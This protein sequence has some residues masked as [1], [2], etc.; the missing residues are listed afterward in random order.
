MRVSH[1]LKTWSSTQKSIT[2]SSA[3]AEL[4]AA[5]KASTELIWTIQMELDWGQIV[6][7]EVYVD[8][9][10]ALAVV[11]GKGNGKLRH[12]KVGCLWIQEKQASGE[13]HYKRVPWTMN[14]SDAMT[15]HL[16]G[17]RLEELMK[18]MS[19]LSRTGRASVGLAVHA[20]AVA[21]G[22]ILPKPVGARQKRSVR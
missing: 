16:S 19:H 8:S 6:T 10:A 18:M 14:P 5:V 7:G 1:C 12:V 17:N 9:S 2:L 20:L 3:E 13:L 22:I 21:P 15:K 11:A 4:V